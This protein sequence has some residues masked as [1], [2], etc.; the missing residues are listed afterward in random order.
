MTV[1]N[2]ENAG[3][4]RLCYP[5][6]FGLAVAAS[7]VTVYIKGGLL[8]QTLRQ[9]SRDLHHRATH[10][11]IRAKIGPDEKRFRSLI[12][13]VVGKTGALGRSELAHVLKHFSVALDTLEQEV[14][15]RPPTRPAVQCRRKLT[16]ARALRPEPSFLSHEHARPR[17]AWRF[18]NPMRDLLFPQPTCTLPLHPSLAASKAPQPV[19]FPSDAVES[20][21]IIVAVGTLMQELF[22]QHGLA[23][24]E[25]D[26]SSFLAAVVCPPTR[27]PRSRPSCSVTCRNLLA[28]HCAARLRASKSC[29][30]HVSLDFLFFAAGYGAHARPRSGQEARAF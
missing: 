10:A 20:D 16:C 9:R 15:L 28:H 24:G 3:A 11:I 23:T 14:F 2:D 12:R 21:R 26:S 13:E 19:H 4:L 22:L 25:M 27:T 30:W 6:F 1:I 7:V 29:S 17:T 18:H 8:Y 5:C